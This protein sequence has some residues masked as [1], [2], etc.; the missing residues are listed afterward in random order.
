MLLQL[1]QRASHLAPHRAGGA[2][3]HFGEHRGGARVSDP[4]KGARDC[5]VRD[6]GRALQLAKFCDRVGRREGVVEACLEQFR[7]VR[8]YFV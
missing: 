3:F 5:G 7:L 4:A 6:A 2:A 1:V 8:I